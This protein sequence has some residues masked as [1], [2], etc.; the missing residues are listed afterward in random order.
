MAS[1]VK[2]TLKNIM[3]AI[4]VKWGNFL[5]HTRNVLFP[6]ITLSLLLIWPPVA[7]EGRPSLSLLWVGLAMVAAG[8]GLRVLTIGLDYIIRGGRNRRV[9]AE[10]L[11]TGGI[12]AHCRNPLY[13]GNLLIAS[14]F[15]CVA[16]NPLGIIIGSLVF[17][18][19]YRLIVCCEEAFLENKFGQEYRDF[20]T[21]VPRWIPRLRGLGKTMADYDFNW[22]TVVVK[23]YG[24]LMTSLMVP[25]GLITWKLHL[26][27]K[28]GD[29]A[30]LLGITALCIMSAYG[31]ARFLKKTGR[32]ENPR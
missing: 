22:A 3:N 5:F 28:L 25:L 27:N 17:L 9:Y 8:Q 4:F 2:E 1:T 16:G 11:V 10:R 14:G 32:I 13:V 21:S 12:F 18:A 24:T 7:L 31:Y 30:F 6:L 23:E 20:C 26:A 19:A 29:Y 15:L